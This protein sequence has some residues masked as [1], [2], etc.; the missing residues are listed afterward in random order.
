MPRLWPICEISHVMGHLG[1]DWLERS[2]REQE[3]RTELPEPKGNLTVEK[4]FAMVPGTR[5]TLL[6]GISSRND[7]T[8]YDLA[9]GTQCLYKY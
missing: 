1:A 8:I 6:M 4:L 7:A 5:D 9:N 3:E 2:T